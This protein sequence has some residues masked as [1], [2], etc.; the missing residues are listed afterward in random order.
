M[1]ERWNL[2]HF[3]L[4]ACLLCLLFVSA[5]H[6]LFTAAELRWSIFYLNHSCLSEAYQL[7]A[8]FVSCNSD[9]THTHTQR[10]AKCQLF[11]LNALGNMQT[12]KAWDELWQPAAELHALL[13]KLHLFCSWEGWA[14]TNWNALAVQRLTSAE[15][16]FHLHLLT[17]PTE[18]SKLNNLMKYSVELSNWGA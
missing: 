8:F 14:C 9:R 7:A 18:D 11:V 15:L 3:S 17:G 4:S 12:R 10:A 2:K 13:L 6:N 16:K 5:Y 1:Q